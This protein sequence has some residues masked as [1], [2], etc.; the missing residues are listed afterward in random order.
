MAVDERSRHD[1]YL[2]LESVLGGTEADTLMAHLPPVGWADVATKQDVA[3]VKQDITA[4]R[5]DIDGLEQRLDERFNVID[6]RFKVVDERFNGLEQWIDAAKSDM[7]AVFRGELNTAII[8]QTRLI[9]FAMLGSV[10][11]STTLVFAV[12]RFT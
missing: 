5:R 4:V 10:T 11:T 3:A 6:A 1:L 8:S 7:L 9:I 2:R 12:T